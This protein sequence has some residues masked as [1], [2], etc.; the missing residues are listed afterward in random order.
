MYEYFVRKQWADVPVLLPVPN[1]VLHHPAVF[2]FNKRHIFCYCPSSYSW[3][4]LPAILP[5][6]L[7]LKKYIFLSESCKLML[8]VFFLFLPGFPTVLPTLMFIKGHV[9]CQEAVSYYSYPS[10]CSWHG[11]PTSCLLYVPYLKHMHFS[12]EAARW[13]SC[14]S[15]CSWQGSLPCCPP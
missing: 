7:F 14:P 9:F 5:S 11:S 13:C 6:L 10:S 8:L 3:R 4:G 15:S 2:L 12:Q 1:R